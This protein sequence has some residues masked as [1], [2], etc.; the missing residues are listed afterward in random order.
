VGRHFGAGTPDDKAGRPGMT[1]D[2]TI[3]QLA[4]QVARRLTAMLGA[5]P[6]TDPAWFEPDHATKLLKRSR[7]REQEERT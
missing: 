2:E 7:R 6:E 1:T 5:L 3:D 4:R